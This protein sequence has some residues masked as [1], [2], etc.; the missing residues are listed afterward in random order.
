[1]SYHAADVGYEA[2][3]RVAA[4]AVGYF[5]VDQRIR[6]VA[7][8]REW[9][10][11]PDIQ[12][13]DVF[14]HKTRSLGGARSAGVAIAL[15]LTCV[16]GALGAAPAVAAEAEDPVKTAE[17]TPEAT[18]EATP[19]VT[20]E[21]SVTDEAPIE[22]TPETPAY[23]LPA[24]EGDEFI[25]PTMTLPADTDAIGYE[26]IDTEIGPPFD[27]VPLTVGVLATLSEGYT[28]TAEMPDGWLVQIGGDAAAFKVTFQDVPCAPH[29]EP[30]APK[31]PV[32]TPPK[33]VDGELIEPTV[34]LPADGVATYELIHVWE[35]EHGQWWV[36]VNARVTDG[37]RWAHWKFPEGWV[38]QAEGLATYSVMFDKL[39]CEPGAEQPEPPVLAATGPSDA[40]VLGGAA[41]LT[42]AA[43]VSLII[44]RRRVMGR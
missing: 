13:G 6:L 26:W 12:G 19:E 31:T 16:I 27:S 9:E 34:T 29:D 11:F 1:M 21:P 32:V 30:I 8:H 24:C 2:R 43:G 5:A 33:C 23:T 18:S 3:H 10:Q 42:V 20:P 36:R 25:A 35:N 40:A 15:G 22:V 17:V 39:S 7:R 44:A 28:W 38:D 14:V 4:T 37:Y 41:L